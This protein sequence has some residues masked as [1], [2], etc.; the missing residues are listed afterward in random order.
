MRCVQIA[1]YIEGEEGEE[2]EEGEER[3]KR[4][5]SVTATTATAIFPLATIAAVRGDFAIY[6]TVVADNSYLSQKVKGITYE[7]GS[8][9]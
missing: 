6:Q 9:A 1:F 4:T 2:W 7:I 3:R 5:A 8:H